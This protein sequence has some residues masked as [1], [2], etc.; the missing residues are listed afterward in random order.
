[1][2]VRVRKVT[3]GVPLGNDPEKVASQSVVRDARQY[4]GAVS[5]KA[6]AVE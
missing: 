4:Q 6:A 1:V 2:E 5:H 3:A